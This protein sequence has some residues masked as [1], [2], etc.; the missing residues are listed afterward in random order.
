M[1]FQLSAGIHPVPPNS[2]RRAGRNRS[3]WGGTGFIPVQG[4]RPGGC[5]GTGLEGLGIAEPACSLECALTGNWQ[6]KSFRMRSYKI[7][8][9]KVVWNEHLQKIGVGGG[10]LRGPRA[11]PPALV[12]KAAFRGFASW[13]QRNRGTLD[14]QLLTPNGKVYLAF[15]RIDGIAFSCGTH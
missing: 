4:P 8:R 10:F 9:L 2:S 7:T 14:S 13:A 6:R 1:P 11:S 3:G 15:L 12:S 5:S